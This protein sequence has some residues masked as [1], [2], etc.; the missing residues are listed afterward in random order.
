MLRASHHEG[1]K[2]PV[3]CIECRWSV[4]HRE[5]TFVLIEGL[6]EAEGILGIILH[7]H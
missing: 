3:V 7:L 4:L 5:K 1:V 6:I 2:I